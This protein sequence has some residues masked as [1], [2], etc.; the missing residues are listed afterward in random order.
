MRTLYDTFLERLVARED[1]LELWFDGSIAG[2]PRQLCVEVA[3]GSLQ[4][5]VELPSEPAQLY[6]VREP[7]PGVVTL[8]LDQLEITVLGGVWS[9]RTGGRELSAANLVELREAGE[10]LEAQRRSM[11][12]ALYLHLEG[13]TQAAL[14]ILEGIRDVPETEIA[15]L[16][17]VMLDASSD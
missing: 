16:R 13:Q 3:Q 5:P 6:A 8:Y 2:L 1:K 14:T 15:S 9:A 11:R 4:A 17:R 7:T 10:A 12:Q